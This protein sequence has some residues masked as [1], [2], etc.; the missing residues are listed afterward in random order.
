MILLN[1]RIALRNLR[2]NRF[3]SAINIFGLALSLACCLVIGLYI[4]NELSYDRFHKN[5]NNIVRLTE[6]QDQAGTLYTVAVTPGP[7]APALQRDFPQ[8]VATVRFGHW[9][10]LLKNGSNI[11]EQQDI[12]LTDN[13]IFKV[14][15]FP[16]IKGN[17]ATALQSADEIVLTETMADKYFGKGWKENDHVLGQTFRLNN[18]NDFKLVGIVKDPPQNS[19]IHFDV[20]LPITFLFKTDE[21]SNKW[22]SNNFHTYL[23]LKAGTNQQAFEAQIEKQLSKYNSETHDLLRL[24]PLSQQ[25]LHSSFD[26][27]TDWGKRNS[28]KYIDIFGAVGLMLFVIACCNFINLSTAR[29]LNRA[30]EVGIRKVNGASRRQLIWQFLSES[31]LIA[32]IAGILAVVLLNIAQ[33]W[34]QHITGTYLNTGL[35]NALLYPLFACFIVII[36]VIAGFYPAL[37]LSSFEPVRILKKTT[38]AGSGKRFRQGLVVLQFTIAGVLIIC[39]FFMY[40]QL[41]FIQQKDLGFD[42]EQVVIV[43]LGDVL[44]EK[45]QLFRSEVEKLPGVMATAPATMSLANVY[46]S[47]YLEWDGMQ[48]TDKFLITQANVDPGFIPALHLRLLSGTNFS[49]QITNDTANYIVNETA[50]KQMGESINSV[51][52]KQVSFWGT[53]GRIIGVVKDFHFKSLNTGIEPF[54]FRYQPKE[55]YFNLFVKLSATTTDATLHQLQQLYKSYEKETPFDFSFL[56][57]RLEKLYAEDKRT[58]SVILLFSGFTIFI[59]CLGLFGLAVYAAEQRVKEIGIRKVL[60]AGIFSITKLLST[61]FFKLVLA[62]MVAAIPVAWFATTK[63]LQNYT[64]RIDVEWSVF[65]LSCGLIA[66]I[67][68]LTVSLYALKAATANPIKSL[69]TD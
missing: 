25:Y 62:G 7:L 18:Q 61:D 35:S 65:V 10:G 69:R 32:C 17:A 55:R 50:V 59:A 67:A 26:F 53:K 56:D 52:Y 6:K 46:N 66:A 4:L 16:L 29:S 12:Q 31:T 27:K 43:R 20:L 39:T 15:N 44:K 3:F 22:N 33:P 13:S 38:F 57:E 40:R 48:P 68:V 41:R 49:P 11:F 14:F 37:I 21:W 34:L 23:L 1:L 19:S 9:S 54:I 47:S 5:F 2:K 42:K 51:L 30:L 58:A 45:P 64:Y 8:V 63:W 28:I 24:Q 60:G 36:G